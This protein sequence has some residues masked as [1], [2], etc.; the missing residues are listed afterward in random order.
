MR[1]PFNLLCC[2]ALL[3][4]LACA[5]SQPAV[6]VTSDPFNGTTVARYQAKDKHQG[7]R[8]FFSVVGGSGVQGIEPLLFEAT[9]IRGDDG[10]I[11]SASLGF[12]C[13][14]GVALGWRYLDC[15]A[16][17]A[18]VDGNP[19]PLGPEDYSGDVAGD[20]LLEE[21]HVRLPPA[22]LR[23]LA[24]ARKVN[25]RVC[26]TVYQLTPEDQAGLRAILGDTP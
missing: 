24:A 9:A 12:S 10:E 25:F 16:V 13:S 17:E 19:F 3:L 8:N 7:A 21:I 6:R 4:G 22:D 5:T 14:T 1:R 26:S 18:L 11:K 15:H 20:S 23:A 2:S